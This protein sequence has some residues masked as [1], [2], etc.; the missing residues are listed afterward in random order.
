LIFYTSALA[1]F[2]I[3]PFVIDTFL[4]DILIAPQCVILTTRCDT[5]I[6]DTFLIFLA[7][8]GLPCSFTTYD[9]RL[10]I[11]T[12][13]ITVCTARRQTLAGPGVTPQF[14]GF[15]VHPVMIDTLLGNIIPALPGIIV[16]YPVNAAAIHAFLILL[17]R[18]LLPFTVLT[19]YA[20]LRI[21]ALDIIGLTAFGQASSCIVITSIFTA[22]N[23]LIIAAAILIA[24]LADIFRFAAIFFA[25]GNT[26]CGIRG[27]LVA[28]LT[29]ILTHIL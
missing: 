22:F 8:F 6:I 20:F 12:L 27:L 13:D 14:A 17:T 28:L 19:K 25:H 24:P 1:G 16:T 29:L 4:N 21:R 2:L 3:D 9:L 23:Q 7:Q 5:G 18:F 15:R 11:V 10:F 26:L